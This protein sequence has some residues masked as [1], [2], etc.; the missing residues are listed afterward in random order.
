MGGGCCVELRAS[1]ACGGGFETR[2]YVA[3]PSRG[4]GEV[5]VCGILRDV[6][7][8]GIRWISSDAG[9]NRKNRGR[10]TIG[11]DPRF[12]KFATLRL[13]GLMGGGAQMYSVYLSHIGIPVTGW[14][15]SDRA[16]T[17]ASLPAI[18]D[19]TGSSRGWFKCSKT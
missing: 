2:P 4:E 9:E 6:M 7:A 18:H 16:K 3:S 1:P 15:Q 14:T 19:T 5:V 13:S 12:L 11:S 17:H 8:V 10:D